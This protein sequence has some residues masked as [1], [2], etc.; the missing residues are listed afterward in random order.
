[1]KY[2]SEH[3]DELY[4][5]SD[6]DPWGFYESSYEERKYDR[7]LNLTIDR[8]SAS[9]VDSVLELGCG[10][11]A[12]TARLTDVYPDADVLGVDISEEALSVARERVEGATFECAEMVEWVT[13]RTET[14]DIVFASE[15]LYYPAANVT[16]TE[17]VE[18]TR[19]LSELVGAD[20]HL[21]SATIHREPEGAV[22]DEDRR[23]VRAI[24][25]AL[26]QHLDRVGRQQ[27]TDTKEEGGETREYDYEIWTFE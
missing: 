9:E 18:F 16:V 22:T 26:E 27:Y 6:G 8:H 25:T 20:G 10:N 11:G 21:I 15:C 1:V 14:F 3:F 4:R 5:S 12:F 13:D 19:Q 23:V 17:Y 2:D 7:T 24:R